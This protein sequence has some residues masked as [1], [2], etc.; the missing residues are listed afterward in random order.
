MT[1]GLKRL[2]PE[3]EKLLIEWSRMITGRYFAHMT[4]HAAD[5][6]PIECGECSACCSCGSIP[7]FERDRALHFEEMVIDGQGPSVRMA[8]GSCVYLK[9]GKCSVYD[10][11]PT[12]CKLF[13]CRVSIFCHAAAGMPIAPVIL[14]AAL[15]QMHKDV[16]DT[17]EQSAPPRG[18]DSGLWSSG[19]SG[20]DEGDASR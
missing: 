13:D 17:H 9:D 14:D 2:T 19:D 7:L 4:L 3:V 11:R 20:L 15:R 10:H 18:H 16:K 1:N 6:F 12:I 8:E 5:N